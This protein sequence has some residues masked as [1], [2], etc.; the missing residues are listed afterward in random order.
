MQAN[1]APPPD[2]IRNPN[3]QLAAFL[4]IDCGGGN[5]AVQIWDVTPVDTAPGQF[6]VGPGDT[7]YFFDS[8][9]PGAVPPQ[10]MAIAAVDLQGRSARLG[11]PTKVT[12]ATRAQPV[13]VTGVPPMHVDFVTPIGAISP[14]GAQCQCRPGRLLRPV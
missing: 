7:V 14:A 5:F 13:V 12:I 3:L 6:Q 9:S 11:A 2:T 4:Q 8:P 1:P 10:T